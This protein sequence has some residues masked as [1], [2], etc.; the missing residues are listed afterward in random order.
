MSDL[1][2]AADSRE[3]QFKTEKAL[4]KCEDSMAIWNRSKSCTQ[5]R[6]LLIG[7]EYS[8]TRRLSQVVS[9][10]Q[11]K[12][13]AMI[14]AKHNVLKRKA[15]A[16]VKEEEAAKMK[17]AKRILLLIEAA[18]LRELVPMV[19]KYY[20]GAMREV[21]E[22]T[23]LHDSLVAQIESKYGKLDEEIY[24]REE[25]RYW[26]RRS[27]AQSLRDMRQIG[28]ISIGEQA[29]LE[30]LGLNPSHVQARLKLF[31]G[32]ENISDPSSVQLE[33]FLD[34]CADEYC[35]YASKKLA[36]QGLPHSIDTAHLLIK[37][38][39]DS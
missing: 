24:E 39:H 34:S 14:E 13:E 5:V 2:K 21:L 12:K 17:G 22:L 35:N 27:F 29:L 9:E 25:N 36:R 18:S 10:L 20:I 33:R 3:L 11:R 38:S 8:P 28:R 23:R 32:K 7:S 1:V 16:K 4:A 37:E 6:T 30:K 26:I 15:E 19:K 31:L